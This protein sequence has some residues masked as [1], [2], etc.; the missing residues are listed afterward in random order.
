MEEGS[1]ASNFSGHNPGG[2]GSQI[3]GSRWMV[4]GSLAE[5][6]LKTATLYGEKVYDYEIEIK[7]KDLTIFD[8]VISMGHKGPTTFQGGWRTKTWVF[9]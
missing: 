7:L 6:K 3:M 8:F 4:Q 9:L 5:V 2:Y 1:R